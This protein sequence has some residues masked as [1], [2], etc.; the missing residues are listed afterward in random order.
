MTTAH[1]RA[2][3]EYIRPDGPSRAIVRKPLTGHLCREPVE[4]SVSVANLVADAGEVAVI[5]MAAACH[6]W[7]L[8]M[9]I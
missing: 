7:P 5:L 8:A 6:A 4:V 1:R 9:V 3:V 2:N